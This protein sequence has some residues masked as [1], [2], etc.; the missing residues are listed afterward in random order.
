MLLSFWLQNNILHM[1]PLSSLVNKTFQ[2]MHCSDTMEQQCIWLV[3][4]CILHFTWQVSI[5]Y[6]CVPNQKS[7]IS[8]TTQTI[9]VITILFPDNYSDSILFCE[10][11][12]YRYRLHVKSQQMMEAACVYQ[13][14]AVRNIPIWISTIAMI[15][16]YSHDTST[17]HAR[18]WKLWWRNNVV[19]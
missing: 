2:T 9:I 6:C 13:L 15:I 8:Y 7:K 1:R 11:V 12:F 17:M 18:M 3:N 14:E 5:I 16:A 10:H 19:W 4:L